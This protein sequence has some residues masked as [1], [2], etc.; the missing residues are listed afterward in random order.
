MLTQCIVHDIDAA[1]EGERARGWSLEQGGGECERGLLRKQGE[2]EFAMVQEGEGVRGWS[3]EQEDGE[4]A[5]GGSRKRESQR[6][7]KESAQGDGRAREQ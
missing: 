6:E 1:Q 7:K 2:E 5:R 3:R 4:H